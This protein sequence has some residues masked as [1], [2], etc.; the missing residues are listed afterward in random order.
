MNLKKERVLALVIDLFIISLVISI[1]GSFLTLNKEI[2]N[3]QL[4]EIDFMLGYSYIFVFYFLY[5]FL[6]DFLFD[7]RTLGKKA[8]NIKVVKFDNNME[9]K[10]RILRS[11]LKV[12]SIWLLPFSGLL[13][14]FG[15]YTFHDKVCKS[16][17]V[18]IND[19]GVQHGK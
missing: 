17:T 9:L 2:K 16:N 19:N 3:F 5:F 13:F 4:F 10:H 6:F 14:L 15:N 11:I 18:R 1:I 8:F 12:I 7:G